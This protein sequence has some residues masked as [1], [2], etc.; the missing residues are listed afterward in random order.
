MT[1]NHLNNVEST[2]DITAGEWSEVG[3]DN[4]CGGG[5]DID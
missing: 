5:N 2:A 4:D 3:S 1:I